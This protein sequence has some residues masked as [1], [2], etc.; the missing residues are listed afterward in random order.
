MAQS[1]QQIRNLL[2]PGLWGRDWGQDREVDIVCDVTAD[3][4]DI[5][6]PGKRE[7][8]FT[9]EEIDNNTFKALF[10]PRVKQFLGEE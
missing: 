3:S 5:I 6:A 8:L 4:L 2:L 1:L 7:T 9:R 10:A